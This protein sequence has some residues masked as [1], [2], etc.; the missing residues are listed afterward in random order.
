[1]TLDNDDSDDAGAGDKAEG[2][3]G[4]VDTGCIEQDAS[5]YDTFATSELA[6]ELH[7]MPSA[8][9]QAQPQTLPQ[10]SKPLQDRANQQGVDD[11]ARSTS[12]ESALHSLPKS[13]NDGDDGW[14]DEN[15]AELEKELGLALEEEQVKLLFAGAPT[16]PSP[17]PV[18]APQ[19]ETQSRKHGNYR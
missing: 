14:T 16:S 12:V 17:R 6:S 18:E 3:S 1:V 5:L 4:D 8:S 9:A 10:S 7:G 15:T 2:A 19:N 11:I 13:S